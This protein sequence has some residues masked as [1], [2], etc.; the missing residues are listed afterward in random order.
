MSVMVVKIG[1]E[2]KAGSTFMLLSKSGIVPPRDT[3]NKVLT[4]KAPP[5]TIPK[6][7]SPCKLEFWQAAGDYNHKYHPVFTCT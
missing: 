1:L 3:A 2:A 4:V 6:K 7:I 5:S